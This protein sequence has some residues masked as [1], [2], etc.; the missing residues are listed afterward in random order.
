M[1]PYLAQ[2]KSNLLLMARDRSVLFFSAVFPL[3]FFFI[4]AQSFEAAKSPGAMAQVLAAVIIIGVLGNGFFGAGMRTVQ[5]RETNVLRRFKVAPINAAPVLVA[6]LVSGLV[7]FIPVVLLFLLCGRIFYHAPIPPNTGSLLIFVSIG[8]LTFRAL[9]MIIASVVNSAQEGNI[10]IQLFYLPMLFLSGATFPISIMPIWLRTIA[11]FLPA[12]YLYQGVQSI[13]IGGESLASNGTAIAA[14]LLAMAVSLFVGIKLFRWEKEEK[15]AGKAK[16]WI[17][18]VLAP[19][20]VLGIYQAKTQANVNKSKI[21]ARRASRNQSLLYTNARIFVG[22]GRLIENGAVLIRGGKIAEVLA[23]TPADVSQ[24]NATS[25]DLSGKTLMPGLIDMHVHL[26]A[27]GG[28]YKD[29]RAYMDPNATRRRLAAYLYS[30]IVAVRSTGDW[31]DDS[32][33]LRAFVGSGEYLG[34]ELMTCGP[35]FTAEG[36]HPTEILAAM[37]AGARASGEKQFLRLPKSPDEARRQ[38]DELKSARVDCTKSVL[39][40]GSPVLGH[41]NHLDPAIYRAVVDQSR[42]DGLVSATHT[43]NAADVFEAAEAGTNT[44]EHG[45]A[46]DQIPASTLAELKTKN[47][48]YDPTLS[49]IE[50]IVDT[51]LGNAHVLSRPLLRQVASADL[52]A[53]T[54]E[55]IAKN[56]DPAKRASLEAMLENAN[57]NLL[58]AY[59]AGVTLIAGS[60]AGNIPVIHGPTIQHELALWIKAGVPPSAALQAAT[61]N[62]AEALNAGD[63]LGLI[64]P[65]HEA[66]LVIIDGDPVVD[67]TS[68][69]HVSAVL[70]KGERV[71]R[72]ELLRQDQN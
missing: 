47:I 48:A 10:I 71:N 29:T 25:I 27:P 11:Q 39:E 37:P 56:G 14:L 51:R 68:L 40:N 43:G 22:D 64:A 23:Q 13:V 30:G 3:V 6:S 28:V 66:S 70:F 58:N 17:L 2:I 61:H 20:F 45:S 26:G 34:A 57:R 38:V 54:Q 63:R 8:L 60:D 36:G 4:F 67:V 19:F 52:L 1:K 44:V 62:A 18:A 33:K 53:A 41:F 31:L 72:T 65:G 49:V 21:L 46:R 42:K 55:H 9:G 50:G 24:F 32:L 5:D 7:N 15:I 69:E 59:K 35:L 12:T 16:L